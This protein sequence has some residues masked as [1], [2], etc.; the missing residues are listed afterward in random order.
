MGFLHMEQQ[1]TSDTAKSTA[2][3]TFCIVLLFL[4]GAGVGYGVHCAM[5][6]SPAPIYD[7]PFSFDHLA[8]LNNTIDD[9][10]RRLDT[11]KETKAEWQTKARELIG[12]GPPVEPEAAPHE[13]RS[14]S[15]D[16]KCRI[17]WADTDHIVDLTKPEPEPT[18]YA[19]ILHYQLSEDEDGITEL[20]L[21]SGYKAMIDK[22]GRLLVGKEGKFW[23]EPVHA[24]IPTW[25]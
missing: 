14:W 3:A 15:V 10:S 21:P 17:T 23:E 24:N 20:R 7:Q 4:G 22:R 13:A 18:Y 12:E 19:H 6:T 25:P 11:A 16:E 5:N 8:T 1:M 9:L 2:L